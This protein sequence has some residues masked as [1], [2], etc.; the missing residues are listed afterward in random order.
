MQLL[1]AGD[2]L[3]AYVVKKTGD[4]DQDISD[5]LDDSNDE[6]RPSLGVSI[7]VNGNTWAS[8]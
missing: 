4:N 1:Q 8:R 6:T 2:K 7:D 5:S 3:D